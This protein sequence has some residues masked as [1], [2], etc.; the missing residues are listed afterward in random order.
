MQ[1]YAQ[2]KKK[3]ISCRLKIF[4]FLKIIFIG[5]RSTAAWYSS[6]WGEVCN[7]FTKAYETV[8]LFAIRFCVL[9]IPHEFYYLV[10]IIMLDKS[11]FLV[12]VDDVII[13]HNYQNYKELKTNIPKNQKNPRTFFFVGE[14]SLKIFFVLSMMVWF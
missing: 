6:D 8:Y 11:Y 13:L 10:A 7:S 3:V 14:V 4:I 1:N 5:L 12:S 9:N 2:R